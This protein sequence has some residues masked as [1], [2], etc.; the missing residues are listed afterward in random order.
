MGRDF[1]CRALRC[2]ASLIIYQVL[3]LLNFFVLDQELDHA[4]YCCKF[5]YAS[6]AQIFPRKDGL[7]MV[8]L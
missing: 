8:S 3:V 7:K 2:Q 5:L 1:V 4:G 6:I